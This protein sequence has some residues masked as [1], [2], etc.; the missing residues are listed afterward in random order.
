MSI[1]LSPL[2]THLNAGIELA[3]SGLALYACWKA[4]EW[5]NSHMAWL[6]ADTKAKLTAELEVVLNEAIAWGL[7]QLEAQEKSHLTIQTPTGVKG[8][9]I[10]HAAQYAVNHAEG[11]LEGLGVS[12]EMLAQKLLAKLPSI[13]TAEDTTGVRVVTQPVSISELPP[14]GGMK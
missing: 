2:Y 13:S 7:Q 12:P 3:A 5:A 9:V 4:R 14:A 1:D 10:E 11:E 6:S 8:F